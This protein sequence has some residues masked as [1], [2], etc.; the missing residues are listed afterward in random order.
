MARARADRGGAGGKRHGRPIRT[1][2]NALTTFESIPEVDVSDV[3]SD[4]LEKRKD[5]ARR[6]GEAISTVGFFYAVNPPVTHEAIDGAFDAMKAFFA[7]PEEEKMQLHTHKS[8][9]ARGYEP[10]KETRLDSKT[11]GDFKESFILG[12]DYLDVE[13]M[14]ISTAPE[15]AAH[16][17]QWPTFDD[18]FR[19]TMYDYYLQ[20][21]EFAQALV[22]IY[23][24]ALDLPE[25]TFD[26][27][28]STPIVGMNALQCVGDGLGG[29]GRKC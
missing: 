28:F 6:I 26:S 2:D 12:D 4:S 27:I 20:A 7:R 19:P 14:S 15:G 24:L 1:G 21:F 3:F 29:G 25:D 9:A 23:A 22:R 16:M 10:F 8:P 17:N 5:L 13:Q 18:S 11:I